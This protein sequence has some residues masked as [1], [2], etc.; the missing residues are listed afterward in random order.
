[1]LPCFFPCRFPRH[2]PLRRQKDAGP[3]EGQRRPLPGRHQARDVVGEATTSHSDVG[4]TAAAAP[5]QDNTQEDE[6]DGSASDVG[7]NLPSRPAQLSGPGAARTAKDTVAALAN[8]PANKDAL[9]TVDDQSDQSAATA[10]FFISSRD[11]LPL[12]RTLR[13]GR[14]T[15]THTQKG[16]G[17]VDDVGIPTCNLAQKLYHHPKTLIVRV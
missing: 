13:L 8:H 15:H 6:S 12:Q 9:H 14:D 11:D 2:R 7:F 3:K 5:P 17:G 1:M 4:H 16:G 10:P